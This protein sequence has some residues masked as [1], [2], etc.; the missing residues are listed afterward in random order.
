MMER[1]AVSEAVQAA[2]ATRPQ[3]TG[4][5]FQ[6]PAAVEDTAANAQLSAFPLSRRGVAALGAVLLAGSG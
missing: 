6:A 4:T 5:A 2:L 3:A 1:G